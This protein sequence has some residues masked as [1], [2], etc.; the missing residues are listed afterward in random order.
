MNYFIISVPIALLIGYLIYFILNKKAKNK[1][2]VSLTLSGFFVG[3]MCQHA[4]WMFLERAYSE[5]TKIIRFFNASPKEFLMA[6]WVL[7]MLML[8]VPTVGIILRSF[9]KGEK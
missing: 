2:N 4:L 3:I 7:I 8:A 5:N 1:K 9:D 6:V